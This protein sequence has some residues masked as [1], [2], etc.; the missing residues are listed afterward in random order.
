MKRLA[1]ILPLL[2]L[3]TGCSV[4]GRG[5]LPEIRPLDIRLSSQANADG[6]EFTVEAWVLEL[7]KKDAETLDLEWILT[8]SYKLVDS[9]LPASDRTP[10]SSRRR[11][12][13][14][15]GPRPTVP[16]R[17]GTDGFQP[18]TSVFTEPERA[19]VFRAVSNH[20]AAVFRH[21]PPFTVRSSDRMDASVPGCVFSAAVVPSGDWNRV[22]LYLAVDLSTENS[23]DPMPLPRAEPTMSVYLRCSACVSV[24]SLE[25]HGTFRLFLLKPSGPASASAP[26]VPAAPA[27]HADSA[28][29]AK[30]PTP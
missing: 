12:P 10:E 11:I 1:L 13:C 6:P 15:S 22:D 26:N 24:P 3:A 19:V 7:S 18:A 8:D 5:W 28:D 17:G 4:P 21:A 20:C 25:K 16:V 23:N 14:F 27:S 2:A 30:E 29:G 9:P